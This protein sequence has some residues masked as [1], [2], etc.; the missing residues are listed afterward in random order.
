MR[1]ASSEPAE[2]HRQANDGE[3]NDV[4]PAQFRNCRP[5]SARRQKLEQCCDRNGNTEQHHRINPSELAAG[6]GKDEVGYEEKPGDQ[7]A[8]GTA[9]EKSLEHFRATE[10]DKPVWGKQYCESRETAS[11]VAVK[12]DLHSEVASHKPEREQQQGIPGTGRKNRAIDRF[13]RELDRGS[14]IS[15]S[16]ANPI[17]PFC[18]SRWRTKMQQFRVAGSIQAAAVKR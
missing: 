2:L 1:E 14:N 16:F 9:G 8:D 13:R 18:S 5:R 12:A 3:S 11:H 6:H 15:H 4:L 7:H 10:T 17:L